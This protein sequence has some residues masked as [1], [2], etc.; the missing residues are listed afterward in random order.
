MGL[1]SGAQPGGV[2][3]ACNPRGRGKE[4][5]QEFMVTLGFLAVSRLAELCKTLSENN[6][7]KKGKKKRKQ[8]TG[9]PAGGQGWVPPQWE[10]RQSGWA[11]MPVGGEPQSQHNVCAKG[12]YFLSKIGRGCQLRV[13][14]RRRCEAV[15]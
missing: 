5:N 7:K 3:H 1:A 8:E 11:Q 2:A 4:E 9:L 12:F 14:W 10:E 15:V 6:S 13:R